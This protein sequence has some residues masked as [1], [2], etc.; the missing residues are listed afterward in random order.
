MKAP[1]E[2]RQWIK[3]KWRTQ[4]AAAAA[5]GRD[6]DYLGDVLRGRYDIQLDLL[7]QFA[8]FGAV[9]RI[10]GD[11][12]EMEPGPDSAAPRFTLDDYSEVELLRVVVERLESSSKANA[13]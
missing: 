7:E 10:V 11:M 13:V 1:A 9:F 4:R 12:L 8:A 6:E 3:Q 2:L 5:L